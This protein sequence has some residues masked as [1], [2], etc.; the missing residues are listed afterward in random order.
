MANSKNLPDI[1]GTEAIAKSWRRLLERDRNISTLFS[2]DSFTTGETES[3]AGKPNWRT[4]LKRLFIYDGKNFVNL[5]TLIE[6]YEISYDID[7]PDVPDN[8]NDLQT[9]LDLLVKRNNLNTVT[10]PAEGVSYVADGLT[11]SYSLPRFTSNKN[12]LNIFIDGVK[13]ATNTYELIDDGLTVK[14]KVVPNKG[15]S[16]EIIQNASL[17][18]WDYSPV[19]K[20]YTGNGTQKTFDFGIEALNPAV[21]SVNIDG[22]ELQKNTFSVNGE[23]VVLENAPASG[24]SVQISTLGKTTYVTVSPSSIGTN[25]LKDKSVTAEKLAENLPVNVNNIPGK[26]ITEALLGDGCVTT[27]KLGDLSVTSGKILNGSV[28]EEK[29]SSAVASR[30][31]GTSSVTTSNIQDKAVT[32]SKLSDSVLSDYYTKTEVDALINKLKL[33]LGG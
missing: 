18:E 28:T 14:F 5:F 9:I 21:I 17:L 25:E 30:L 26:S 31:L 24:A 20:Y 10:F 2:G 7:H 8:V 16:I 3:D 27:V 33:E 11:D 4:D 15:E 22:V 32:K 19:I 6:P 1:Q 13:Q 12:T 29:L 23:Q